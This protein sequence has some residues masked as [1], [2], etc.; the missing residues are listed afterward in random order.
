M[1]HG[2]VPLP[3]SVRA[4]RV[5]ENIDVLQFELSAEDM[6]ELDALDERLFTEWE[7]GVRT[8]RTSVVKLTS[9]GVVGCNGTRE[10]STRVCKCMCLRE[11]QA[12]V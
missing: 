8:H 4:E 3:K 10:R 5:A 12:P 1:Q 2:Y 9:V 11:V 7:E 6:A